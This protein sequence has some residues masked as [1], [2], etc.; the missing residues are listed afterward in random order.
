MP[1]QGHARRKSMYR[2]RKPYRRR[3]TGYRKKAPAVTYRKRVPVA[4]RS[5]VR[6]NT[7]MIRHLRQKTYGNIQKCLVTGV[8]EWNTFTN[9]RPLLFALDDFSRQTDTSTGSILQDGCAIWQK[10]LT[11]GTIDE[12]NHFKIVNSAA[13]NP[14]LEFCNDE[15]GGGKYLMLSNQLMLTIEGPQNGA[16]HMRFRITVFAQKFQNYTPTDPNEY[17]PEALVY[18]KDM[19]KPQ[20]GNMMPRKSFSVYYDKTFSLNSKV[21]NSQP[22][23][24]RVHPT[25]TN[26][27]Y[28]R[29]NIRPNR[30]R[31]KVVQQ[32]N[33]YPP[34]QGVRPSPTQT[35]PDGGWW[36]PANRNGQILWCLVSTDHTDDDP[37]EDD[38]RPKVSILSKRT[39][40]DQS[41]SYAF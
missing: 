27:V 38:L 16:K 5:T 26:K 33:T 8:E 7:M 36:G 2:A 37:T 20:V 35:E 41:G 39:W 24:E 31:G 22:A 40:R 29:I 6:R 15:V 4:R 12:V 21:A 28:K 14:F 19:A 13:N 9:D 32:R 30:G 18:L 11:L 10:N 1:F 25:T 17:L 34:I 23:G 3:A